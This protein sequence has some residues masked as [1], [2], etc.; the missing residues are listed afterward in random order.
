MML[1]YPYYDRS[2]K[3]KIS[4]FIQIL[5]AQFCCYSLLIDVT[6]NPGRWT[7]AKEYHRRE[8]W[9]QLSRR[10]IIAKGYLPCVGL[11]DNLL[12]AGI[13]CYIKINN[14]EV[15]DVTA[16]DR[17][18]NFIYSQDTPATLNDAM[19]SDADERF[20]KGMGRAKAMLQMDL[21]TIVM[22]AIVGAGA[23]AGLY[24]LGVF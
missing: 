23:I 1:D 6:I 19:T 11:H 9:T 8:R 10:E 3:G 21:Q 13:K 14:G 4:R 15:F 24:F 2:F 20:I 22:I 5:I 18:G 16:K 12:W 7:D 17:N